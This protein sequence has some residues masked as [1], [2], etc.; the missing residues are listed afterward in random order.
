[1]WEL[2]LGTAAGRPQCPLAQGSQQEA[3]QGSS[4]P[5]PS[6]SSSHDHSLHPPLS[7]LQVQAHPL[8]PHA[9]L[10]TWWV[11][12]GALGT[13]TAVGGTADSDPTGTWWGVMCKQMPALWS[14]EGPP[15]IRLWLPAHWRGQRSGAGP[16]TL[17]SPQPPQVRRD[18]SHEAACRKGVFSQ[19]SLLGLGAMQG[20]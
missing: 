7:T 13:S 19:A 20:T 17:E 18:P 16:S 9:L 4:I 3:R 6:G 14:G 8:T 11:T 12:G 10:S 2:W 15:G 5:L 1:M